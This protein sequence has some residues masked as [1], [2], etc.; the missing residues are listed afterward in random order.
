MFGSSRRVVKGAPKIFLGARRGAMVVAAQT[1]FAA[2][3]RSA[4][5]P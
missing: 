2:V 1:R 3:R 5:A 4:G